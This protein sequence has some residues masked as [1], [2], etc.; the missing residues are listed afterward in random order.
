MRARISEKAFQAQ[1]VEL[2]RLTGWLVYHTY[3]SRQSCPGWPD[4]AF[5]HPGRGE[6]F[7]AELKSTH[8]RISEAQQG[9]IDA[10][11]KAGIECHVWRPSD[12][13]RVIVQR[14]YTR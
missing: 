1:I 11:R 6:F 9:W 4:V 2:A 5:C 3:D 12:F 8:G 14:L 10:L 7:M 13:E